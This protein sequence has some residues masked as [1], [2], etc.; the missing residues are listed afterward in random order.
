MATPALSRLIWRTV[1]CVTVCVIAPGRVH[2]ESTRPVLVE[3][4]SCGHLGTIIGPVGPTCSKTTDAW[5]KGQRRVCH[6]CH[7]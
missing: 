6:A 3:H 5:R 1:C 2:A 7:S 4:L